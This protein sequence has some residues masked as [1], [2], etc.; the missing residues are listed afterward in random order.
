MRNVIDEPEKDLQEGIIHKKITH[1]YILD[2]YEEITSKKITEQEKENQLA[3]LSL[4]S[5]H[6]GEIMI[7]R[8]K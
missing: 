8:C 5:E 1:D 4:L 6:I 2:L 7:L 3:V